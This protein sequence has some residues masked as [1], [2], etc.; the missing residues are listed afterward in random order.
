MLAGLQIGDEALLTGTVYTA[1]DQA[2][3][4]ICELLKKGKALPVNLKGQVIYYCG[5]TAKRPGKVIGSCGPTT[6]SRMDAFTPA[7]LKAGVKGMIGKGGRSKEVISAIKR[8]KAVY[9]LAVG[10]AGAYLSRRVKRSRAVV[11]RDLG[12]EAIH[13]LMVRDFP[14]IVGIDPKGRSIY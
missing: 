12:P 14:V 6:S 2:H 5:P 3:K 7:L 11:F 1:R 4:R 9:F 8:H 10:G 13:E